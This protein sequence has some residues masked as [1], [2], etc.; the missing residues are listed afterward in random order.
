MLGKNSK[1][2]KKPGCSFRGACKATHLICCASVIGILSA[3]GVKSDEIGVA[4]GLNVSTYKLFDNSSA[5][6]QKTD[7]LNP[8]EITYQKDLTNTF[9]IH[10]A[11]HYSKKSTSDP[12]QSTTID[13]D[14][15]FVDGGVIYNEIEMNYLSLEISPRFRYSF[16]NK[17]HLEARFGASGDLYINEWTSN[18]GGEPITS[19]SKDASSFVLSLA[20]GVGA[21]YV[22]NERFKIGLKSTISRTLTDIYNNQPDDA[23][24]FFL[25]YH[26]VVCFS[27]IL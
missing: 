19:R 2:L 21:G 12:I 8:L 7:I 25:N 20:G 16:S 22:F 9:G 26:N 6:Y 3:A 1:N 10:S 11:L 13:D 17:V 24:I 14:G 4:S 5:S 15:R 27:L 18:F 23:D